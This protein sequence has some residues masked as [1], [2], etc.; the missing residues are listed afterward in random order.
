[1]KILLNFGENIK[2]LWGRFHTKVCV[3]TKNVKQRPQDNHV[4]FT[5]PFPGFS[6]MLKAPQI[7]HANN[8]PIAC[9]NV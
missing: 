7:F 3:E 1:M 5:K 4:F 2:P 6:I 8:I 9:S